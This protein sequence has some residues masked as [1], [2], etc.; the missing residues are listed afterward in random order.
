MKFKLK[1]QNVFPNLQIKF[2]TEEQYIYHGIRNTM[3]ISYLRVL[4]LYSKKLT[5]D[6]TNYLPLSTCIKVK[7]RLVYFFPTQRIYSQCYITENNFSGSKSNIFFL[8]TRFFWGLPLLQQKFRCFE[9]LSIME[10]LLHCKAI[11]THLVGLSLIMILEGDRSLKFL[12]F[13][14]PSYPILYNEFPFFHC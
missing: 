3:F 10:H 1:L 8:F 7:K 9:N 2:E 5:F 14:Q 11:F 13:L 6:R 4:F 12:P